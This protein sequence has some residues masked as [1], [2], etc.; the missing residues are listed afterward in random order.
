MSILQCFLGLNCQ[1]E[2]KV[3]IWAAVAGVGPVKTCKTGLLAR[4]L[5]KA[6]FEPINFTER[7]KTLHEQLVANHGV[8]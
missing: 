1:T 8:H 2:P 7:N 5:L 4:D 3:S 6:G